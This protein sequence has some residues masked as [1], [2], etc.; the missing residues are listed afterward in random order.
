MCVNRQKSDVLAGSYRP[1]FSQD[2][3]NRRIKRVLCLCVFR[4][5]KGGLKNGIFWVPSGRRLEAVVMVL[6][7]PRLNSRANESRLTK[8]VAWTKSSTTSHCWNSRIAYQLLRLTR[9]LLAY[10]SL[11]LIWDSSLNKI[12]Q[13]SFSG[14]P[15][16]SGMILSSSCL[17]TAWFTE[18]C[19][20]IEIN[21][22]WHD[23]SWVNPSN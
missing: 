5:I 17:K 12:D 21:S 10:S 14:H 8:L 19:S 18:T 4:T 23:F 1:I 13:V 20:T 22:N 15:V 9:T 16:R 11:L 3:I 7:L 2:A 6:D